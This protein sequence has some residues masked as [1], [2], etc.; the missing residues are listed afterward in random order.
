MTEM[1]KTSVYLSE[2]DR[3]RLAR[4]ADQKGESQAWVLREALL[5]YDAGQPDKNFAIFDMWK[6]TPPGAIPHFDDPQEFNDWLEQ[7]MRDGLAREYEDQLAESKP[8]FEAWLA[9]Q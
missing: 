8:F 2:E 7:E 6:D 4:L 1:K 9:R 3:Q 5:A